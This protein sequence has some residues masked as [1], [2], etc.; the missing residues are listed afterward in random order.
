MAEDL[1]PFVGRTGELSALRQVL[2][3]VR[4]GR[5]QTVLLTGPAGIGKTSLVE[6]FLAG[7]DDTRL[8][9]ASGEQWEAL[10]AFGVIDQ[11]LRAAGVRGGFLLAGR[12]RALPRKSR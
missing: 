2:V 1:D 11:L 3:R 6:Q 7:L 9:R 8:L 4:S 5:P 12:T 10:V